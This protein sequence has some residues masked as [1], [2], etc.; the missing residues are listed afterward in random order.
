MSFYENYKTDS[1]R[2]ILF[3][4]IS[5]ASPT[6]S[7]FLYDAKLTEFRFRFAPPNS[8]RKKKKKG[9]QFDESFAVFSQDDPD[10]DLLVRL[11]ARLHFN[12][13][14]GMQS[15]LMLLWAV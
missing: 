12:M 3:L 11:I 8:K 15:I 2:M 1:N 5:S 10:A 13:V 6:D 4:L 7:D 14:D 9:N